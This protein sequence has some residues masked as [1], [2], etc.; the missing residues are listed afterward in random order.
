[1]KYKDGQFYYTVRETGNFMNLSDQT[2]FNYI[3]I[4]K[5]LIEEG[6]KNIIP[7]PTIINKVQCFSTDDLD[8]INEFICFKKRGDILAIFGRKSTTYSR[9]KTENQQLIEEIK[10]LSGSLQNENIL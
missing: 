7:T 1:M 2:I 8:K 9:L 4:N 3:Y 10:R 5:K 6:K